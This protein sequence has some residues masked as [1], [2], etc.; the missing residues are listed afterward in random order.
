MNNLHPHHEHHPQLTSKVIFYSIIKRVYN[1]ITRT[2]ILFPQDPTSLNEDASLYSSKGEDPNEGG[3]TTWKRVWDKWNH[4][5]A[6]SPI[7]PKIH[8]IW[9]GMRIWGATNGPREVASS[10]GCAP[11]WRMHHTREEGST[12][13]WDL[14]PLDTS[15]T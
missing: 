7:I 15:H 11:P 2:N 6:T 12:I 8:H 5:V 9:S 3:R 10:L 13:S 4:M 14:L 1:N